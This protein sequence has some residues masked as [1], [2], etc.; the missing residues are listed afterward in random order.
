MQRNAS[1]R[2]TGTD[3]KRAGRLAQRAGRLAQRWGQEVSRS[4]FTWS[5]FRLVPVPCV[6]TTPSSAIE[7]PEITTLKYNHVKLDQKGLY[8]TLRAGHVAQGTA[9]LY[10]PRPENVWLPPSVQPPAHRTLHSA[11]CT[12]HTTH[13]KLHNAHPQSARRTACNMANRTDS[14]SMCL[15]RNTRRTNE[16][17]RAT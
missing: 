17:T 15:N 11:H 8:V 13:R 16:R 2:R 12:S 4:S 6:H 3:A 10:V 1:P 14:L 7:H 5:Y 9:G